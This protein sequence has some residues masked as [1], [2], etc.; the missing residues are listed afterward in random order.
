MKPTVIYRH[1]RENL[2][3]CSLTPLM[4]RPDFRFLT[5]PADP[6]PDLAGYIAL[7]VGAPPLTSA[8]K[9]SG[10]FLIDATWRLAAVMEKSCP[11]IEA[12]S[13]P[14][15]F[16]TAYPRRQ[17]DCPDPNAGLASIEAIYLAYQILG[18]P[19]DG[20]LD[21]YYWREAFLLQCMNLSSDS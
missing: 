13:L 20:L 7:Q 8:D 3:K 16:R 18:R 4:G 5:Y 12:R 17:T 15:H 21:S 9:D 19:T 1:R 11:K 10:L 2:A 14:A 6:L